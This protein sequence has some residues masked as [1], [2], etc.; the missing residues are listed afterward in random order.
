M[1]VQGY[2]NLQVLAPGWKATYITQLG[3]LLAREFTFVFLVEQPV[4]KA[5]FS[6]QIRIKPVFSNSLKAT[7]FGT[8]ITKKSDVLSDEVGQMFSSSPYIF[9]FA[10]MLGQF[11]N[12]LE[13]PGNASSVR[14]YIGTTSSVPGAAPLSS[15]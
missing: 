9:N 11:E 12:L 6:L 4:A 13:L 7:S 5:P 8:E 2:R 14:D 3:R 10:T 15:S 1:F